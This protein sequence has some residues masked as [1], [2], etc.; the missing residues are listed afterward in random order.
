M[1]HLRRCN[2]RTI[3]AASWMIAGVSRHTCFRA[4]ETEGIT[5]MIQSILAALRGKI[6]AIQVWALVIYLV[7]DAFGLGLGILKHIF[8]RPLTST[9]KFHIGNLI[10]GAPPPGPNRLSNVERAKVA[11]RIR[12]AFDGAPPEYKLLADLN[13]H[14]VLKDQAMCFF[15]SEA[16][17]RRP[18]DCNA[19]AS[20]SRFYMELLRAMH[21]NTEVLL[22]ATTTGYKG[23]SVAAAFFPDKAGKPKILI[24]LS[25]V[26]DSRW[27]TGLGY[28]MKLYTGAGVAEV[29]LRQAERASG[30]Y[31]IDD[32]GALARRD[33]SC[34]R[35]ACFARLLLYAYDHQGFR[36][37]A[38]GVLSTNNLADIEINTHIEKRFA[39]FAA[40]LDKS[41][42]APKVAF[43]MSYKPEKAA[44]TT[45]HRTHL[46][47]DLDAA[48]GAGTTS[49]ALFSPMGYHVAFGT[50]IAFS[51]D[52]RHHLIWDGGTPRPSLGSDNFVFHWKSGNALE[53]VTPLGHSGGVWVLP[54][55]PQHLKKP[56]LIV[57]KAIQPT[58]KPW[59]WFSDFEAVIEPLLKQ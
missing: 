24:D 41:V 48:L 39:L 52:G 43:D 3:G 36:N 54:L 10:V 59:S 53:P 15:T 5:H 4:S 9:G 58:G 22:Y 32:P 7:L 27:N 56:T 38:T 12:A 33:K 21:P 34:E 47:R 35:S 45:W 29:P 42:A 40:A 44:I 6:I 30:V 20:A 25:R 18:E 8:N 57:H 46:Q 11:E 55:P 51:L 37:A 49:R 14:Y 31:L 23:D 2:Q 50:V 1:K 19:L 16:I 28:K 17:A 26:S 13:G